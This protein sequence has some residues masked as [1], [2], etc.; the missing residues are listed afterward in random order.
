MSNPFFFKYSIST[1]LKEKH[2]LIVKQQKAA[3]IL[4]NEHQE[5]L[6]E[7]QRK[8]IIDNGIHANEINSAINALK[9][10]NE[11]KQEAT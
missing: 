3:M 9:Q 1:L 5:A 7:L 8:I 11:D 2:L 6:H 4:Q 10:F